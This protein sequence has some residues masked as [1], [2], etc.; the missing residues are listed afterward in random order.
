MNR[1]QK[2]IRDISIIPVPVTLKDTEEM[3][4]TDDS[5]TGQCSPDRERAS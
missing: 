4:E 2:P 5:S 3:L 1:A